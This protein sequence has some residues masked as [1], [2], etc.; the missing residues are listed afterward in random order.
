MEA[1]CRWGRGEEV[2]GAFSAAHYSP[3][4]VPSADPAV[5]QTP[6]LPYPPPALQPPPPGE[7]VTRSRPRPP[8]GHSL[9][10]IGEVMRGGGA[11]GAFSTA[12]MAA[13]ARGSNSC[14]AP[15]WRGGFD[16][17]QVK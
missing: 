13:A 7:E 6:P 14:C 1:R 4:G 10:D 2:G 3:H 12:V 9:A 11:A 17:S 15:A 16:L 5:F 8:P